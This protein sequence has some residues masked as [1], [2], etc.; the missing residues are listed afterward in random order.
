[1]TRLPRT[2]LALCLLP[3]LAFAD[4]TAFRQDFTE[5]EVA[6]G[7]VAFIATES[8]GGVV[9]GNVTV[10]S[11]KDASLVVDSGQY[12]SL[13]A[14]MVEAIRA[15]GL[16]PV[17]WLVNTHWHGDHLMANGVFAAAWPELRV[18][19]H[20]E[21]ARVAPLYY[22]DWQTTGVQRTRD[23]AEGIRK[24]LETGLAQSGKPLT[25]DQRAGA[26]IDAALIAQWMPEAPRTDWAPPD[27]AFDGTLAIDLGGRTV[28]LRHPGLANTTGDTVL[29]DPATRT[30]VTGDIVVHPTP[31]SFGS[32]HS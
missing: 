31:Y 22:T 4:P 19:Q 26:E 13:A 11:V 12:P 23:F 30:V 15:A 21:T 18:L 6:D 5:V 17:R 3:G 10:V 14:R 7:I 8:P 16:P 27:L 2:A 29:W 32:Y 9:Q 28:E 24:S 20:A 1:M 25:A